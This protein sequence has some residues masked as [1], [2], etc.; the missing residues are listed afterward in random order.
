MCDAYTQLKGLKAGLPHGDT[1]I[2]GVREAGNKCMQVGLQSNRF[3]NVTLKQ[4]EEHIANIKQG[5]AEFEKQL[6]AQKQQQMQHTQAPNV[7]VRTLPI[8]S[9]QYVIPPCIV[10]HRLLLLLLLSASFIGYST[11]HHHHHS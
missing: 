2:N 11:Y 3:T 9:N 8:S 6:A 7:Q 5:V 4:L 1:M 10:H